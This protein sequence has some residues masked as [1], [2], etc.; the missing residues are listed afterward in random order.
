MHSIQG[1]PR[2]SARRST[3]SIRRIPADTSTS[4]GIS[5]FTSSVTGV[6]DRGPYGYYE[7][8]DFGTFGKVSGNIISLYVQDQWSV[9]PRLSLNLGIRTENESVPTSGLGE[10]A[11]KFGFGDKL[12]PRLGAA[13]D[14]HGDGR[15][16]V[17]GSW[18]RY[19]DW[20]KYELAR[21]SFGGDFWRVYYRSL[22]TLDDL[23]T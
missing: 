12:A 6:V 14:V 13:Y 5:A 19:F 1:R 20:T 17:Y 2:V 22:D 3:T 9:T 21:G 10:E 15:M 4:S 23:S 11:F 7:V 8:N 18:G 16:K